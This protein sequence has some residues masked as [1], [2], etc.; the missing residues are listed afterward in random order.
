MKRMLFIALLAVSTLAICG[1]KKETTAD[2]LK[3]AAESAEKDAAKAEK[4]LGKK[5]DNALQ[6]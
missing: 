2:K 6:Q 4:D 5:L 1:C 3:D